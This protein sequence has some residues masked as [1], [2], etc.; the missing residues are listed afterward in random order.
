[1]VVS[2]YLFG[3]HFL[4]KMKKKYAPPD[5]KIYSYHVSN[6]RAIKLAQDHV[7]SDIKKAIAAQD[8]NKI[9]SLVRLFAFL[10]G[11]WAECR[12]KKL[13]YESNGFIASD[14]LIVLQ[15]SSQIEQWTQAVELGFCRH[16]KIPVGRLSANNMSFSAFCQ[17][18]ELLSILNLNLR[19]V[20][21]VRNKLA[22]GQWIYPFNNECTDIENE[23]YKA[24]NKED[25]QTLNFKFMMVNK[26]ADI[27][28]DLVVSDETF[29]RDFDKNYRT[30][31]QYKID[32]TARKYVDYENKLISS[33]KEG[34]IKRATE[35]NNINE[36]LRILEVEN[37]R[38]MALLCI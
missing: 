36:Q 30:L 1:L 26:L 31:N 13:L 22:H 5:S 38:L 32:L 29:K 18:E 19:P 35:R 17:Y 8:R 2:V 20:I 33:F 34:K 3:N 27:I 23:K 7:S 28:H 21:E 14:R 4:I 10:L 11:A 16:F 12:L 37:Q 6:L 24:I 25:F 9:D 15:K